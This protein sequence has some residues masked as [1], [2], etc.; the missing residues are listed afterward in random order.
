MQNLSFQFS[1]HYY[2]GID[3]FL[4]KEISQPFSPLLTFTLETPQEGQS[5]TSISIDAE[6]PE[7]S[8]MFQA[9]QLTVNNSDTIEEEVIDVEQ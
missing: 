6:S 2:L 1:Y 4:Q 7:E 9:I 8:S 3:R 5:W